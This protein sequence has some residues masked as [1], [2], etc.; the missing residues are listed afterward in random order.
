MITRRRFVAT[1]AVAFATP[2]MA[3]A[4]RLAH[5]DTGAMTVL[6]ARE[7]SAPLLGDQGS[8]T[9]VWAYDGLVPGPVLRARR[10]DTL[11]VRLKNSLSQPTSLHWH[12]IRIDNAMDGVA[13]LTQDAVPPGETFDYVFRVPDAGTFWYHP[14]HR[15]WEQMAR[16]LYGMLI[17]DED[18]PVAVDRDITFVADDWRIDDDGSLND[19]SFGQ[20][21]EWAHGG[22]MG[23]WLTINGRSVPDIAVRAGERIRLRCVNTAN[24]RILAFGFG[25]VEAHLVA[26]D[27][28]PLADG[29]N[30][31]NNITLAPAQRADLVLD[32]SG[33][34]G[35]RLPIMEVSTGETFVAAN[36]VIAE[37]EPVRAQPLDTPLTLPVNL[38]SDALSLEGAQRIE[39]AMEGG[40][41]GGLREAMLDGKMLDIQELVQRGKVW[42]FNGV[43]GQVDTRLADVAL[44]RTVVINI[45]NDT[46]WPHAM[47]LHGHHFR[48]VERNGKAV[49]GAPWR[50]TEL[51]ERGESVAIAFVA[52]N[53]GKWLLHCHMLEHAA[54]GMITY[55]NVA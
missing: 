18:E 52:D 31:T 46:G 27:G 11:R 55:L 20:M 6:E 14:H 17:I 22:R 30:K 3:N 24:A 9:A 5:A 25:D 54:A 36:L 26:L 48:V 23:N 44:G 15:S 33:E 41:M 49:T 10:G 29:G 1:G 40:A 19:E 53:P 32:V 42:S 37:G 13:G 38:S 43:A 4:T 45:R 28:Q 21:G 39:L 2:F 8:P 50:D 47:H 35:E 12:G 34:P 7:A 16:G 51:V